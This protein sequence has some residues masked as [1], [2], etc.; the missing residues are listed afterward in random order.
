MYAR[1]LGFKQEARPLLNAIKNN[2]SIP[3]LSKMADASKKLD[4][5]GV[6]MLK[7]DVMASH[8]YESIVSSKF[9]LPL[10]NEYTRKI[11]KH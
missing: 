11:V 6:Q 7:E 9:N 8:V 10:S 5:L 4:F 1:M 2:S 3:L